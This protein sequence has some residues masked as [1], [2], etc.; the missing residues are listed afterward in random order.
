M[1]QRTTKGLFLYEGVCVTVLCVTSGL[2]TIPAWFW[3]VG[4]RYCLDACCSPFAIL[5]HIL[6]TKR[7]TLSPLNQ[8]DSYQYEI[9]MKREV[10]EVYLVL[11]QI[12]EP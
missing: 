1:I 5:R 7:H 4:R 9:Y 3:M 10:G 8:V 12:N 2:Y 11:I 6:C